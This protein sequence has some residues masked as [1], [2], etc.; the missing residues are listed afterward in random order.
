MIAVVFGH[1]IFGYQKAGMYEESER[2]FSIITNLIYSFHMTLFFILSGY[3]LYK[4][5]YMEE[6]AR[7]WKKFKIQI[8]NLIYIYF[9]VSVLWWVRRN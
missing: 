7:T 5:Y 6:N 1:V 2:T 9:V 4:A 8:I 3:V